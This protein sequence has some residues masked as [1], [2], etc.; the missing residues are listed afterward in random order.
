MRVTVFEFVILRNNC[1][2]IFLNTGSSTTISSRGFAIRIS[3]SFYVFAH[4]NQV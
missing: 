3:F 1:G 2:A 4:W